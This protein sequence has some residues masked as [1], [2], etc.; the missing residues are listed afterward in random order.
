MLP[1]RQ[2][3]EKTL[4]TKEG[5]PSYG[6]IDVLGTNMKK[7]DICFSIPYAAKPQR[8]A[9]ALRAANEHRAEKEAT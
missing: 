5:A 6:F 4:M 7:K 1:S 3:Q 8:D 2:R 9:L